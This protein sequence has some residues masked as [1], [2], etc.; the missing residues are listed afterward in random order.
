MAV[1]WGTSRKLSSYGTPKTVVW[2]QN[3]DY[4]VREAALV[5][6]RLDDSMVRH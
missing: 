4:V 6:L 3:V 2:P 1:L 5:V